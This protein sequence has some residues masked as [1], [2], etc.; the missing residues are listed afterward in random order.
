MK[1]LIKTL[2][3]GI[4]VVTFSINGF[5]HT[6]TLA[7]KS[8]ICDNTYRECISKTSTDSSLDATDFSN[9]NSQFVAY[10]NQAEGRFRLHLFSTK[11]ER[12][13][14]IVTNAEGKTLHNGFVQVIPGTNIITHSTGLLAAGIYNVRV[15]LNG[16]MLH[17]KLT[18]A[19]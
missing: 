6:S 2:S 17:E 14:L 7:N 15:L 9:K 3:T 8:V 10:N 16:K 12:A 19:N 1:N 11:L 13:S 18:V 5:S 4:M